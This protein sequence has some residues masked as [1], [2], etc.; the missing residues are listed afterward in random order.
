MNLFLANA[1]DIRILNKVF[2]SGHILRENDIYNVVE[3]VPSG[4][5]LAKC[6]DVST[7][8]NRIATELQ[9]P[10]ETM[11]L[12]H[13]DEKEDEFFFA[14]QIIRDHYDHPIEYR[15]IIRNILHNK[16]KNQEDSKLNMLLLGK[17]GERD[18]PVNVAKVPANFFLS[19]LQIEQQQFRTSGVFSDH[20]MEQ[21]ERGE[22]T[23]DMFGIPSLIKV[24]TIQQLVSLYSTT[25]TKKT[26]RQYLIQIWDNYM[27][28]S[29]DLVDGIKEEKVGDALVAWLKK[30]KI[31]DSKIKR[32]EQLKA[33]VEFTRSNR[34]KK[35]KLEVEAVSPSI[36]QLQALQELNKKR[37]KTIARLQYQVEQLRSGKKLKSCPKCKKAGGICT[38]RGK[39]GHLPLIS[40]D[41][42]E[43]MEE[44]DI[45]QRVFPKNKA[46]KQVTKMSV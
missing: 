9:L 15:Q 29:C 33:F 19:N 38:S 20:A 14:S 44:V 34:E 16:K 3:I 24:E 32:F 17:H 11:F 42:D 39:K 4:L 40:I 25:K 2:C 10:L 22:I 21:L 18:R 36:R 43:D 27:Q 35:R 12:L 6:Q 23:I 41:S 7:K 45:Q 8:K 46:T 1:E 37:R 13:E 30:E 26:Y 31:L 5:I 28:T